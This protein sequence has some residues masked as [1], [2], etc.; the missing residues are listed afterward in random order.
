MTIEINPEFTDF[1]KLQP[2]NRVSIGVQ[3]LDPA[4]LECLGRL[5]TQ[6][7][8]KRAVRGVKEAGIDNISIDLMMELPGQT[9]DSWKRTLDEALELPISHVS[10]YNLTFEPHTPFYR[11]RKELAKTVPNPS[12]AREMIEV[13]ID[14]FEA[15]NLPRYEISAFGRPSVH[16]S[17]YWTGRPFLGIGPSAFSYID[18]TRFQNVSNLHRYIQALRSGKS[19]I[20]FSETLSEEKSKRERLAIALRLVRGVPLEEVP[21]YPEIDPLIQR[22]WLEKKEGRL[23]LSL[24]GTFFYDSVATELI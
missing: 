24:E 6:E 3:S 19:P 18:G 15:R 12:L 14:R 9:L 7:E 13:A 1:E 10:L 22:G 17:G 20:G 11:N 16:N 21:S 2:F 5:H 23:A 4:L 8:A